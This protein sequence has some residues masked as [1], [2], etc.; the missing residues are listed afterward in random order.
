MDNANYIVYPSTI[1]KNSFKWKQGS[2]NIFMFLLIFPY[3]KCWKEGK[4][5]KVIFSYFF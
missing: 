1:Y 3:T 2:A 4:H 5:T